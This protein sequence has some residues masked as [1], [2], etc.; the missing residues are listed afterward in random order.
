LKGINRNTNLEICQLD[1]VIRV[2]IRTSKSIYSTCRS[3]YSL[4]L[5]VVTTKYVLVVLV[6][7]RTVHYNR[8]VYVHRVQVRTTGSTGS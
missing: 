2:S 4:V 1:N 6:L 7:V 8:T 3:T 5:P